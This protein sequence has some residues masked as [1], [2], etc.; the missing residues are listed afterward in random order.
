[1]TNINPCVILITVVTIA[2]NNITFYKSRCRTKALH[3][4]V[5]RK[6]PYGN[7]AQNAHIL[8]VQYAQIIPKSKNPWT[9]WTKW[10]NIVKTL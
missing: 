3:F 9:K 7:I 4:A 2:A 8:F 5:L 1:M 6:M 10:T